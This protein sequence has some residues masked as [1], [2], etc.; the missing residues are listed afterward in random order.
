MNTITV[1]KFG[2]TSVTRAKHNIIKIVKKEKEKN[3]NVIIIFSAFTGI[4]NNLYKL[5]DEPDKIR[6]NFNAYI[7]SYHDNFINENFRNIKIK[8]KLLDVLENINNSF[9]KIIDNFNVKNIAVN[10]FLDSIVC[11]GEKVSVQIYKFLFMQENLESCVCSSELL[12]TTNSQHQNA[13]PNM[14]LTQRKINENLLSKMEKEKIILVTGFVA[15]D[16][17]HK[18]TTL[19]RGGSDF[20]ATIIGSCVNADKIIIYTDV[21]G[22]LTSDPKKNDKA[23]TIQHLNYKHV[24][25]LAYFGA[26]VLHSKT[27]IPIISKHIP[28]F[29]KNTFNL[30]QKGT[31][32]D[33]KKIKTN[34]IIDAITSISDHR[35]ITVHGLGMQGTIGIAGKVLKAINDTGES[36]PFITQASSE[37]TICF[38]INDKS[39]ELICKKLLL[40][41]EDEIKEKKID[42]IKISEDI[43]I[44]TVVGVNIIGNCGVAGEVFSILGRHDINILAISQGTSE[45]SISFVIKKSLEVAAIK[46]LHTLIYK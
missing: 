40:E 22:I 24:S 32:I 18:I 16:R 8:T 7:K 9:L 1:L 21:N 12:I 2:G 46:V 45:I 39:C 11:L 31:I 3:K 20:T 34:N 38:A 23:R 14:E 42:R 35:L 19:G 25:E 15:E 4:T 27:L 41:F 36:T 28:V 10:E 26:K 43:C 44:I 30:D 29:V 17:N 37:Q 5:L 6:S 13:F 33:N